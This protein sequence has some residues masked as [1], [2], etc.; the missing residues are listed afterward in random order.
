[1]NS[2]K[3]DEGLMMAYLYG[4]LDQQEK[5]KMDRYFLENPDARQELNSLR[6][7]LSI[8]SRVEDK[9][10]IAP[11]VLDLGNPTPGWWQSA[12]FRIPMSIAASFLL[13]LIVGK[14]LGTQISLG[15]QQLTI[16]FGDAP[17]QVQPVV[18]NTLTE[19]QVQLLIDQA[20]QNNNKTI[21][22]NLEEQQ[23]LLNKS[24]QTNLRNNSAKVDALIK[25]ASQASQDQVRTFV[26]GL[27]NENLQM[28]K[29]YLQLS[30]NDQKK[31][32]E[33]LLVDFSKYLQEQRKQDLTAFQTR[34]ISIEKNT[35]L[36]KQETEQLLASIISGGD[37]G[38]KV[39]NY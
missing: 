16:R 20:L 27:Q 2:R 26:A 14:L 28:M 33:G 23:V 29:D 4:E 12:Y 35:D 30:S 17:V 19:T 13:I 9:E 38:K 24:I 1:M 6:D 31:Y 11:P 25:T 5:E 39:N 15:H 8:I 18:S 32:M 10:V 3:P 37:N 22:L 34:M 21:A 36:F 7:T